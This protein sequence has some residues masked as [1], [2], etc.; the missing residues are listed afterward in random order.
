TMERITIVRK[1]KNAADRWE[2]ENPVI[3]VGVLRVCDA[4]RDAAY[5]IE[6]LEA[7]LAAY[8]DLGT[9]EELESVVEN[10]I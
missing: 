9:V 4:L 6:A 10:E 8:R 5:A 7:E 2:R 3:G 1:L